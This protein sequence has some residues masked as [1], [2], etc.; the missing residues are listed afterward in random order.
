MIYCENPLVNFGK[1]NLGEKALIT[2]K[3]TNMS[4]VEVEI[5]TP[6]RTSCGCSVPTVEK[7]KLQPNETVNMNVE[8]DTLGKKGWNE[9][10][11]Y[12]EYDFKGNSLRTTC[13][14]I[15]EVV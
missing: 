14:F 12:V 8:F 5:K 4:P 11:V 6:I 9:K 15:G 13:K 7:S 10:E 1:A 2:F 3:L